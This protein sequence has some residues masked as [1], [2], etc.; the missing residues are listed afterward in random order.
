MRTPISFLTWP[1]NRIPLK[2]S[3]ITKRKQNPKTGPGH[4][5]ALKHFAARQRDKTKFSCFPGLGCCTRQFTFSFFC[6]GSPRQG[7]RCGR[8]LVD[9]GLEG[10]RKAQSLGG[11]PFHVSDSNSSCSV[12]TQITR[13]SAKACGSGHLG[14]HGPR[15]VRE[16]KSSD[17]SGAPSLLPLLALLPSSR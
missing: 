11:S 12:N 8:R 10:D 9:W 13:S 16:F 4:T 3:E 15:A 17:R 7:L 2:I 1:R 5:M 6:L 14:K